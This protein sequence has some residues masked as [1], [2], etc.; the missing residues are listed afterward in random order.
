M[1]VFSGLVRGRN[2]ESEVYRCD[3]TGGEI[4]NLLRLLD[5]QPGHGMFS[6]PGIICLERGI[7]PLVDPLLEVLCQAAPGYFLEGTLQVRGDHLSLAV[8]FEVCFDGAPERRITKLVAQHMQ[9]PGA[10]VVHVSIKQF[11]AI[12]V[13]DIVD[14]GT[15]ILSIFIKIAFFEIEHRL[16]KVVRAKVVLVPKLLKVGGKAFVQPTIWPVAAGHE[17][18]EPLVCQ[19]MRNHW[20]QVE[21]KGSTLIHQERE[22]MGSRGGMFHGTGINLDDRL[23]I[24]IVRI[25]DVRIFREEA[26]HLGGLTHVVARIVFTVGAHIVVDWFPIVGIFDDCEVADHQRNQVRGM[27]NIMAP[28]MRLCLALTGN[29]DQVAISDGQEMG[30]DRDNDL[31]GGAIIGSVMAGEPVAV[32]ARLSKCPGLHRARWILRRWF[33]KMQAGARFRMVLYING[34][35]FTM[36]VGP[37][38]GHSE[39]FAIIAER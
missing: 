2:G 13:V 35:L 16:L 25:I 27:W 6:I 17:V 32:V 7:A 14:D 5:L 20:H 1:F 3:K 4:V 38:Q 11:K 36:V 39:F 10:F 23:R 34:E 22:A 9:D 31:S 24:L 29:A 18:T 26:H 37:I 19:L 8:P 28:V 30:R 21:V 12:V 15:A 33:D